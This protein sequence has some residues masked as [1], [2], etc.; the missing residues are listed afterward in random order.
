MANYLEVSEETKKVFGSVLDN[1][2]IPKFVEFE[3][4]SNNKQ[5][6]LYKIMKLNDLVERLTDGINFV[7]VINEEIFDKLTPEQQKIALDECLAGISVNENDVI[8]LEKPD[9]STY[10]GVLQKYGH[11]DII[12]LHESIKSLYD[13][14][15]Q[16]E[17]EEKAAKKGKR[18]RKPKEV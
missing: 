2:S 10:A 18:G 13:V 17:E 16:K 6:F 11:E 12:V 9:F 1:T 15:K 3:L 7:V 8:S 5:K 14:K 4:L